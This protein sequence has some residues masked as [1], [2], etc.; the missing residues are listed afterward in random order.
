VSC[1]DEGIGRVLS[2]LDDAGVTDDTIV[3]FLSD[4]GGVEQE[5]ASNDPLRAGK[6]SL[7]EGGVRVPAIVRWPR[8]GLDGGGT[9]DALMG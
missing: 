4:N 7:Y 1:L 3:W 6:A 9:S 5:G 8:G 2:A